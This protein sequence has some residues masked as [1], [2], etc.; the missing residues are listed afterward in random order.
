VSYYL[1]DG[2]HTEIKQTQKQSRLSR[3]KGLASLMEKSPMTSAT[4]NDD[5]VGKCNQNLAAKFQ[6]PFTQKGSAQDPAAH[7]STRSLLNTQL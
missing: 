6:L 7:Q 4:V 2:A 1:T 5:N 3:S